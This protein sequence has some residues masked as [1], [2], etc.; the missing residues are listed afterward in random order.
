MNGSWAE[1]TAP[2]L[3]SDDPV[4]SRPSA[5][6]QAC[7]SCLLELAGITSSL[8]DSLTLLPL[9][10]YMSVI[11]VVV[12]AYTAWNARRAGWGVPMIAVLGTVSVWYL[13]DPIYNGYE[14]YVLKFGGGPLVDAWWEVLLFLLAFGKMVPMLHRRLNRDF[15]GR[16]GRIFPFMEQQVV[17]TEAFQNQITV[18]TGLI[19]LPWIVLMVIALVRTEFDV[20]GLFFPYFGTKSDPWARDRIGSGIDAVYALAIYV[21]LLF[22]GLWGAVLALAKRPSTIMISG[23][24]Y[25]LSAPFYVFDR[26]R[27]YMLAILMP[28]FL[29]FIA[30]R[31]RGGAVA[32]LLIIVVGFLVLESWMKFV[33]DNRDKSSIATAFKEGGIQDEEV[34][35]RRHLGFNMFEELGYINYFIENGNY[36]VNWGERYFAEIVN[37]IPRIIWPGKPLIGIDYA[38][39]R[40][41][42]WNEAGSKSGGVA[43]SI[44]TGMIGQ[45]VVNFGRILGPVAAAFLMALWVAVLAR[46]DLMGD[47]LGY[48]LL[49]SIGLVLTF[50]MGRDITL[51]IIYPFVFGWLLL[52]YFGNYFGRNSFKI[53]PSTS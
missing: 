27:S 50:N 43:A 22:T 10:Y 14:G 8:M 53:S 18:I 46:Q 30:F 36:K 40:G 37:P 38:V 9:P 13:G 2:G 35:E 11:A 28:G 12:M 20:V 31:L 39:A 23:I 29:A 7:V 48:L 17:D 19:L 25:F 52:H 33:I 21:Q 34:K 24:A 16:E 6:N 51:L 42:S 44:S 5:Q 1:G 15:L 47:S 26:T 41:F 32:R 4:T 49:Y 45:G 3:S